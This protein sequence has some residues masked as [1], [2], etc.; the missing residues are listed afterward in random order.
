MPAT[1]YCQEHQVF[2]VYGGG[3]PIDRCSCVCARVC[4][5]TCTNCVTI[6]SPYSHIDGSSA[7]MGRPGYCHSPVLDGKKIDVRL[8]I[9]L[10][11]IVCSD[12][13]HVS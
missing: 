6:Y 10:D 2:N 8:H 11:I 9:L 7:S 3:V 5:C 12:V 4:V 13:V 1:L